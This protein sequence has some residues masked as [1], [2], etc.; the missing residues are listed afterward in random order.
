M[1]GAGRD[2]KSTEVAEVMTKEPYTFAPTTTVVE[3]LSMI[4]DRRFRHLPVVDDD[5][6][7]A[8]VSSGDLTHW[9]VQDKVQEIQN[10]VEVAGKS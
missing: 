6:V 8:L 4:T 3:A 10:L 9:L 1:P 5:K 7:V 2:P